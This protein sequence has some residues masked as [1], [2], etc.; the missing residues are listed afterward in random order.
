MNKEYHGF[1]AAAG[2]EFNA[3]RTHRLLYWE[4]WG[5]LSPVLGFLMLNPSV[6][7]QVVAGQLLADPTTVRN[8]ARARALGYGGFVQANLY[9]FIAT[10]PRDLKAAGYPS[11]AENRQAYKRMALLCD[12]VVLA[13][14]AHARPPELYAAVI[15]M[16]AVPGGGPRLWHLGLLKGGMPRHPLHTAYAVPLQ[17]WK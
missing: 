3:E 7:G 12:D 10:H 14:G 15:L 4:S 8:R 2:A 17:E 1:P 11:S 9:S 5:P 13:C 6:A 16:R